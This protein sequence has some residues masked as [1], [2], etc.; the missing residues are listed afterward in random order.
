ML[1]VHV[2]VIPKPRKGRIIDNSSAPVREPIRASKKDPYTS[3][4]V[5][6]WTGLH[7]PHLFQTRSNEIKF[8]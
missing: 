4:F 3:M 5:F 1:Y 7:R 8:G 6:E 2:T